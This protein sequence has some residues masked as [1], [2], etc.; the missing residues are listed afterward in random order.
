MIATGA[1]IALAA[2]LLSQELEPLS[3]V[4]PDILEI[5]LAELPPEPE[6]E[7]EPVLPL[8]PPTPTITSEP[9]RSEPALIP[10]RAEDPQTAAAQTMD[11]L[12]QLETAP[13]AP[14]VAPTVSAAG[15]PAGD[16]VT[17]AQVA[18]AL[19]KMHC[20]KLKR[21]EDGDCPPPDPF[22]VAAANAERAIPPERLF[23][24]PRYI[25]KTVSDKIFEKEAASRFHWPDADLFNDPMAPGAYNA[26]RIRNGQEPLW[27]QEMR[28]GFRKS[29]D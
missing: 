28:D 22:A 16:P 5:E 1:H 8:A 10:A 3:A 20:L 6:V 9:P 21:H 17:P 27:S 24:D 7:P 19:A 14:P 23:G 12:T 15:E 29:E 25:A 11:V 18:S 2:L 4:K 13:T 26:R